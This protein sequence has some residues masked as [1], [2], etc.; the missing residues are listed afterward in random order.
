MEPFFNSDTCRIFDKISN[1]TPKTIEEYNTLAGGLIAQIAENYNISAARYAVLPTPEL[2]SDEIISSD[3]VLFQRGEEIISEPVVFQYPFETNKI[4]EFSVYVQN[5]SSISSEDCWYLEIIFRQLYYILEALLLSLSRKKTNESQTDD[6]P[7]NL[8][9]FLQFGNDLLRRQKGSEY[10]A[11]FFNI[12]NFKS[13]HKSLTYT[14]GS[15]ILDIYYRT[16][17]NAVTKNEIIARLGGDNFAAL[18]L[19]WNRDY[20]FDLIQNMIIEYEKGDRKLS[21]SFGATIGAAKLTDE[22]NAGD[23]MMRIT[24]AYQAARDNR[25]S[26]SYYDQNT[27]LELLEHKIILSKFANAINKKEFFVVYQPKVGVKSHEL[28]GAEALVR[29]NHDGGCVMPGSFIPVFEK[30]GCITALDFYVLE[31]TCRF[32]SRLR[33]EGIDMVKISVNFSKRHLSNNKLVEEIVDIIDR[34]NIPHKYI[35]IELTEGEDYRNHDA[36]RE[37]LDELNAL[38]IKTSID[39]FG[40]GYSSLSMLSSLPLDTLKI[41]RS[42]IPKDGT[43]I[44]DKSL[45]M[46]KGVVSLAKNLGL[47]VIAEGVETPRQLNMIEEMNCDIVQGFIFD[48]PLMEDEFVSRIKRRLYI[49]DEGRI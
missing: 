44:D 12:H 36:M 40:T 47:T 23:I 35:E 21:F 19:D 16:V 39:D 9:A 26:F 37:I 8:N 32:L 42:F 5:S 14:E 18:I 3:A 43:S 13:V 28:L 20:F 41:D 33:S 34:Y 10:T 29:W 6:N 25:V 22:K 4:I 48:K 45:V 31:E 27:S 49:L 38:N 2:I 17:F 15:K 46:L 24:A 11:L 1:M 7:V 30:D